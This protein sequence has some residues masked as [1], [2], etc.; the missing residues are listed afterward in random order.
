MKSTQPQSNKEKSDIYK[1]LNPVISIDKWQPDMDSVRL[2][3][4]Q[5]PINP[6]VQK[7]K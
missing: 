6:P 5:L 7:R 1:R 3:L 4:G 2:A